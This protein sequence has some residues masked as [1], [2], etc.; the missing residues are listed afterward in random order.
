MPFDTCHAS[1]GILRATVVDGSPPRVEAEGINFP[2]VWRHQA[3]SSLGLE[4]PL[5]VPKIP[6][7]VRRPMLSRMRSIVLGWHLHPSLTSSTSS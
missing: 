6:Y 3:R 5:P 2:G 4:H 1:V 7:A